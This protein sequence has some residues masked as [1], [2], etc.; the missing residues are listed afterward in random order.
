MW[1]GA[2]DE[3]SLRALRRSIDLGLNFI[4]TALGY[5]EGHSEQLVGQLVRE[6]LETI[7]VATK[8]SPKNL[9]WPSRPGTPVAEAFPSRG[10]AADGLRQ[11][12]DS[13]IVSR[14]HDEVELSCFLGD[15]DFWAHQR[16]SL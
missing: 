11:A 10:G 13:E 2:S 5:G 9:V 12:E 16:N 15:G 14:G 3:E 8:I 6:R 7:C 1:I 4:D